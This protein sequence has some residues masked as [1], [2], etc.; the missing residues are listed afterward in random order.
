MSA[1]RIEDY[2][3]S[4]LPPDDQPIALDFVG[5]LRDNNMEFVRDN[6][7]CWK[8]K[9]YYWV[10]YQTK[11][12]CFIAINDP[13]EEA[14]RWTVWSGDMDSTFLADYP[15]SNEIKELAW[16]HVDEC[17]NCGSCSGGRRKTI[18]GRKFDKVCGCT[19]RIDNPGTQE[20][21]FLKKMVEIGKCEITKA[22]CHMS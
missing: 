5:Y 6:G 21:L 10:M 1:Q 22:S 15:V 4:E 11:C 12:V 13:D 7:E 16:S 14:N 8:D 18:F 2:I 9:I 20:L 17:G 19:F 3:I